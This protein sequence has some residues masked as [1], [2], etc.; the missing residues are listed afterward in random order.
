MTSRADVLRTVQNHVACLDLDGKSIVIIIGD[1]HG[2]SMGTNDT[3]NIDLLL[4]AAGKDNRGKPETITYDDFGK[5]I[6]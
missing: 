3:D 5:V 6:Q 4:L 1:E 2:V